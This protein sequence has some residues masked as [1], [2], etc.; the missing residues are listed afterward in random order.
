VTGVTRAIPQLSHPNAHA[1][2]I[3]REGQTQVRETREAINETLKQAE[4][5]QE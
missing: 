4:R 1:I 2:I 5:M 3:A